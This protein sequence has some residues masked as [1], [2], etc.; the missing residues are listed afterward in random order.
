MDD[1]AR[2]DRWMQDFERQRAQDAAAATK[3]S[4]G[5]SSS[6][7]GGTRM[8]KEAYMARHNIEFQEE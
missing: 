7:K 6:T 1:D 8:S 2:F 3:P 5:S 4:G